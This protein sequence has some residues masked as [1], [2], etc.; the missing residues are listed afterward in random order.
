MRSTMQQNFYAPLIDKLFQFLD[1]KQKLADENLASESAFVRPFI[2]VAREPG[3]GGAPIARAV[4]DKLGFELVD[5]QIIEKIA[6]STQKRKA[7][8]KE[9]DEK[10]RT[11]I[12]DILHS[13]FNSEYMDETTYVHELVRIILTYA[14]KGNTVILGRGANFITP[15]AR[16][17]HVNV[18]APY[19]VRV[20][21]AMDYEGHSESKAKEV[22]AG[23]EKERKEFVKQYFGKVVTKV[24]SYDLSINT[25]YFAVEDA[26]DVIIEALYRKFSRS[27]RYQQFKPKKK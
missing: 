6:K 4:A 16:G 21:R 2:T 9:I 13:V 25:T 26:R 19:S 17:L 24:N 18:T 12:E 15:F 5:E 27:L 1:V 3:S 14:Y 22:I 23:V 11:H 8:V 7:I 10:S 20:Q